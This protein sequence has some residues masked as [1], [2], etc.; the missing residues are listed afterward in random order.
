MKSTSPVL[1]NRSNMSTLDDT[2]AR[3]SRHWF[4]VMCGGMKDHASAIC[5]AA[6]RAAGL[7]LS[8]LTSECWLGELKV[9]PCVCSSDQ[10]GYSCEFGF[11]ITSVV[12]LW[13]VLDYIVRPLQARG[14]HSKYLRF[15]QSRV[16]EPHDRANPVVSM[17][18]PAEKKFVSILWE[19]HAYMMAQR[20]LYQTAP[21]YLRPQ[22]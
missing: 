2:V 4:G 7:N 5:A 11:T 8:A 17:A 15:L 1:S 22:A 6:Q 14:R 3:S 19:Y 10:A 21:V 20:S 12:W 9:R 13:C 18:A 16:V